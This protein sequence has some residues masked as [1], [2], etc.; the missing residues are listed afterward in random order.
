M[1]SIFTLFTFYIIFTC[2]IQYSKQNT[3]VSATCSAQNCTSTIPKDLTFCQPWLQR[4]VDRNETFCLG[5]DYKVI[6]A[7]IKQKYSDSEL[8]LPRSLIYVYSNGSYLAGC[9]D[10]WKR[11][12][13]LTRFP[14]CNSTTMVNAQICRGVCQDYLNQCWWKLTYQ[15]YYLTFREPHGR[16]FCNANSVTEQHQSNLCLYHHLLLF[17]L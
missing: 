3:L 11:F 8:F 14:R 16:D 12:A 9:H 2:F 7:D 15:S 1:K 5:N 10:A 17:L 6:D 4:L 13:C